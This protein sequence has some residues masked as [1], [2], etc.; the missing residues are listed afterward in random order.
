[1]EERTK[2]NTKSEDAGI[3]LQIGPIQLDVSPYSLFVGF[4]RSPEIRK[5]YLQRLNAIR[6]N[7][8]DGN[9][10]IVDIERNTSNKSVIR[11]HSLR[12]NNQSG[13]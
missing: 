2:I 4:I 1:L 6:S 11:I 5:K 12:K 7:P 10:I 9:R 13:I 8:K 3:G